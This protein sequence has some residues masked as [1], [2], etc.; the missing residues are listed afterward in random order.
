MD[1]TQGKGVNA[2]YDAIGKDTFD[3]GIDVLAERGWMVSYGQSSGP[4]PLLQTT[5]LAPKALNVTRV[6]GLPVLSRTPYSARATRR[7]CSS[8]LR[9][10][11]CASR[12]T[13]VMACGT[14][15]GRMLILKIVAR[16][17]QRS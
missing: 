8:S 13:S 12:S 2:I 15:P 3:K 1:L 6:A 17:A 9:T 5:R 4:T 10:A 14:R 16:P 11:P 7:S